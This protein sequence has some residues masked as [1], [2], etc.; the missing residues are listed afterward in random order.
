[1]ISLTVAYWIEWIDR[2]GGRTAG[3][4]R[5]FIPIPARNAGM[6]TVLHTD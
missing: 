2:N 4:R 1:M 3:A 6:G 5:A